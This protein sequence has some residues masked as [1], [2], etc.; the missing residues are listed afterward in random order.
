MFVAGISEDIGGSLWLSTHTAGAMKI[1]RDGFTMYGERDG[2]NYVHA[3][4][5]DGV[6]NLCFKG[7]VLG[8]A[9][10]SVFEGAKLD[11]VSASEPSR[12]ARFGC[13]DGR[14]F[15]WFQLSAIKLFGW[16]LPNITLQARSGEWWV[17]SEGG[18]YRFPRAD[19]FAQLQR[20]RPLA[21]YTATDPTPGTKCSGCSR[22]RAAISGCQRSQQRQAVSSAGSL[23]TGACATWRMLRGCRR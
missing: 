18:L 17:G 1:T 23:T 6:G 7:W 5:E 4:F 22:I 3:I 10:T 2:I 20:A 12:F 9:R 13:F 8:D 21:L 16:V 15:D 14:R 19:H 11:L